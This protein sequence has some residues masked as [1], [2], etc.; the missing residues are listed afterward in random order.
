MAVQADKTTVGTRTAA[1]MLA[2]GDWIAS[3]WAMNRNQDIRVDQSF[4]LGALVGNGFVHRFDGNRRGWLPDHPLQ[5]SHRLGGSDKL[6]PAGLNLNEFQSVT[7]F[8][9]K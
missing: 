7:S 4:G 6:E 2:L 1:P 5:G 8:D 9:T 3:S